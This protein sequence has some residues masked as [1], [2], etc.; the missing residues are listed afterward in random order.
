VTQ[1][2][3]MR[4]AEAAARAARLLYDAQDFDGSAN[5]AYYAM[6]D[7]ARAYLIARHG[8]ATEAIKTHS[9]LISAF[10][11]LGVKHDGLPVD[12]GRWLNQAGEVRASADYG[13][14]SVDSETASLLL[15]QMDGFV[16]ELSKQ[17]GA[18]GGG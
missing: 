4:K 15:L 5:R 10:S 6:F 1:D 18:N 2:D 13:T 16:S 8:I 14:R 7:V 9:G 11:R 12:L 3:L 17:I